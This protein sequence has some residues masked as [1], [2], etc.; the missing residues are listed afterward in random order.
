MGP[1]RLHRIRRASR[2][3]RAVARPL[4]RPAT[5]ADRSRVRRR[6]RR[7]QSVAWLVLI[8]LACGVTEV[9][10]GRPD[11][12]GTLGAYLWPLLAATASAAGGVLAL[13]WVA[14]KVGALSYGGGFVIIPLMQGDAVD[15][16]HWMTNAQFLNEVALGQITP[17]AVV[18]TVEVVG[19]AAAGIAGALLAADVAF[20]SSVTILVL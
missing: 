14:F 11:R 20:H 9:V 12:G 7:V 8:L 2:A 10:A 1:H 16:Y 4:R 18:Q 15:R 6:D 19:F 13:M 3:H 17:G 5:L